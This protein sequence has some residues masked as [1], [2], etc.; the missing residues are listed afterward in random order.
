[1][2]WGHRV[3]NSSVR[4]LIGRHRKH[5]TKISGEVLVITC[6][7]GQLLSPAILP[8]RAAAAAA[9]AVGRE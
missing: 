7:I 8:V 6:F 1:M 2:T 9:A 4:S 5:P 3:H